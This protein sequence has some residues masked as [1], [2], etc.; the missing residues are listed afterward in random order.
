M[1][2]ESLLLRRVRKLRLAA[3]QL[4]TLGELTGISNRRGF[5]VLAEHG[6]HYC[7]RQ[8]VS[9]SLV[10]LDLDKFKQI[11][12]TFGDEKGDRALVVAR[13]IKGSFRESDLCARLGGDG[14]LV[15]LFNSQAQLAENV[16]RKFR[17]SVEKH[18]HEISGKYEISFSYGIVE[19]DPEKPAT[20]EHMLAE[21]DSRMYECKHAKK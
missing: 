19:F 17:E 6:L 10:F 16:I 2:L 5:M 12:D 9:A 7:A 13:L 14:F 11:N 18:R 15:L 20:I 1:I 3:F 8:K 4:A 21:G